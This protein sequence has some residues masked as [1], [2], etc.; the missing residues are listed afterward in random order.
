MRD[1]RICWKASSGSSLSI[2]IPRGGRTSC[3]VCLAHQRGR[4]CVACTAA[5]FETANKEA[6]LDERGYIPKG[7]VGRGLREFRVFRGC[8][9][10]LEAVQQPV[11]H[12]PLA[13]IDGD[14]TARAPRTEPW[15]GRAA[16]TVCAP[17][18]ARPILLPALFCD[19]TSGLAEY[20]RKPAVVPLGV[21]E[22]FAPSGPTHGLPLISAMVTRQEKQIA[23]P[24]ERHKSNHS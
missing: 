5:A 14:A 6:G 3:L 2:D 1:A 20:L 15:R 19:H 10:P 9:F 17:S 22:R 13:V 11:Q 7:S 12:Q 24:Q 23:N 21:V 8:K 18:M 16:S 4:D